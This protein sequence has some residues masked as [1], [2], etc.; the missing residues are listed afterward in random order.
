[1]KKFRFGLLAAAALVT[2][3]FADD[4][5]PAEKP[6]I[7]PV[8]EAAV[9]NE[10]RCAHERGHENEI[11]TTMM[12]IPEGEAPTDPG[13]D[14]SV[15]YMTGVVD[16]SAGPTRHQEGENFRDLSTMNTMSMGSG[17]RFEGLTQVAA[18]RRGFGSERTGASDRSSLKSM[19][20]GKKEAASKTTLVANERARMQKMADVD[21]LRDKALKT[22]DA[23]LLSR[24]DA[25][26]KELKAGGKASGRISL[27]GRK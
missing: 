17:A 13:L 20:F 7:C 18:E 14:P 27:F 5:A 21:Q 22:R 3:A 19:L 15:V 25:M 12:A 6:P 4:T 11:V 16:D 10:A 2:P 1:M 23:K 8:V 9:C 26:E 24:A